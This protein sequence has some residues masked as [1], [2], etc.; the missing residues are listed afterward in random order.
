E[1]NVIVNGTW[2]YLHCPIA[3]A[4]LGAGK[5]LLTEARMA[6]NAAQAHQMLAESR[7]HPDLVAQIVPSPFG[8]AGQRLMREMIDSGFLGDLREYHVYSQLGNLADA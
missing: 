5:H 3:I 6:M 7:R 4:A 2:P 1:I 8:L